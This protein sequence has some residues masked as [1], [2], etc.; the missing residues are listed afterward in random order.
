MKHYDQVKKKLMTGGLKMAIETLRPGERK[1]QIPPED[2]W[3]EDGVNPRTD[4]KK[5]KID[6]RWTRRWWC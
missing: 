3:S 5:T 4:A 2:R 1:I 6:D